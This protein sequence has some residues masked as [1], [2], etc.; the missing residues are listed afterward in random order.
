[1]LAVVDRL[2]DESIVHDIAAVRVVLVDATTG[3]GTS[4]VV[5]KYLGRR[6]YLELVTDG[7][8]YNATSIEFRITRWLALLGTISTIGDEQISVKASKDY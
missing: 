8:G 6:F 7:R 2:A 5:G 1:M 4:I 3:R